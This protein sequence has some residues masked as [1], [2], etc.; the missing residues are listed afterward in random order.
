MGRG[1]KIEKA[2]K[3][4]IISRVMGDHETPR[5]D[6]SVKLE[7]EIRK[8]GYAPPERSTMKKM[9]SAVRNREPNPEDQPWHMGTLSD[10]AFNDSPISRMSPEGLAAVLG[11]YR[12]A[13]Q[14]N[15]TLTIR[16]AK[17]IGRLSVTAQRMFPTLSD[18]EL[19][20]MLIVWATEYVGEELWSEVSGEAF[21]TT[22][23]DHLLAMDDPVPS[24]WESLASVCVQHRETAEEMRWLRARQIQ[25][26]REWRDFPDF[27]EEELQLLRETGFSSLAT[28]VTDIKAK[29]KPKA[30]KRDSSKEEGK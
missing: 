14:H 30:H 7:G 10:P 8:M 17:W 5:D 19:G 29:M 20:P 21:N 13:A 11:A 26:E 12:F 4:H 3:D 15:A 25:E 9:I 27:S 23:V 1:P 6:L 18:R 24:E 16:M 22:R 2:V 28:K